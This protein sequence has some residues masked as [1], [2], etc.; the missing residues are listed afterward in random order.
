MREKILQ[1]L[2]RISYSV[3]KSI[4]RNRQLWI[5]GGIMAVGLLVIVWLIINELISILENSGKI[6]VPMPD[7][8]MKLLDRLKQTTEKKAEV[9]EAPPD[10]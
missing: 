7:F 9:E 3:K 6:G 1:I 8:L 4:R 2:K 5:R 10:N